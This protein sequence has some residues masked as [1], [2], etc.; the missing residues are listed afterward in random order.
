MLRVSVT[1][2]LCQPGRGASCGACCGLYNF[3]DHSRA[4]LTARLGAQ[5]DA[6]RGA[7]RTPEG[8]RAAALEVT[9]APMF[10]AVRVCPL[11]GFLDDAGTRVGCLAHPLSTGGVDLRDC[12][13]YRSDICEGF[14]CPSFTWLDDSAARLVQ[15][16]CADW[17]L[18]GLVITDVDFVRG[19]LAL[20]SR[21]LGET[22]PTE[23]IRSTLAALTAMREL[24]L[25][26]ERAPDR[27]MGGAVFGRFVPDAEGEPVLRLLDYAALGLPAV[28]EDD[29][30]L[31]LGVA[32]STPGAVE[33]ARTRVREHVQRVVDALHSEHA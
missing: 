1:F 33:Q 10:P 21:G 11:L 3:Q 13:R 17:Y 5:T 18:Y 22:A 2:H 29:V 4:A 24:F 9:E 31:C 26:K 12:G 23:R 32:V 15:A 25:L 20:V 19:C 16:A 14:T 6:L 7:P 30:V 28:P 27:L 8:F